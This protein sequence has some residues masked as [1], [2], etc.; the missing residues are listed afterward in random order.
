MSNRRHSAGASW[1]PEG[2]TR[3]AERVNA[4]IPSPAK[5]W[6]APEG[7]QRPVALARQLALVEINLMS[8]QQQG[9]FL[10]EALLPM[11]LGLIS[12]SV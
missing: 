7:R 5:L 4:R 2:S 9:D 3:V 1:T 11:M 12:F 6:Q 8:F 10:S